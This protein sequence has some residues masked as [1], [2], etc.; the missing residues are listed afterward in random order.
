MYTEL[1]Y[2]NKIP[3]LRPDNSTDFFATD[4]EEKFNRNLKK[5]GN[6]WYWA[7]RPFTYKFNS[8]GYRMKE[9]DQVDYDNYIIYFGCSHT[10][11]VGVPL[12]RSYAY[13]ASAQL[14]LDYIN[15]GVCGS[16]PD[17]NYINFMR[18]IE[19]AFQAKKLPRALV[20]NW[21]GINRTCFWGETELFLHYVPR[22]D[23]HND[24]PGNFHQT[25]K[26]MLAQ[27]AHQLKKFSLQRD[28]MTSTCKRLGIPF[29]EFTC[30]FWFSDYQDLDFEKFNYIKNPLN[31]YDDSR[32]RD[33]NPEMDYTSHPGP[34]TH[35]EITK[36][37][38][39]WYRNS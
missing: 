16:S 29:L 17:Y 31:I 7:S 23:P 5:L 3:G 8:M 12:E 34:Q 27:Q 21:P 22:T 6:N 26:V 10:V 37:I 4:S 30:E 1:L 36:Y 2:Y 20:M 38:V 15:A 32:A 24:Y 14:G 39:N 28:M 33:K 19:T 25:Y 18:Y 11:G 35:D 13:Q 9:L